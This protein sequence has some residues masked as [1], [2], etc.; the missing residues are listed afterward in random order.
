[1]DSFI[2]HPQTEAQE[3]AVQAV[4]EALDIAFEKKDLQNQNE[5]I[6]ILPPHVIEAIR[7]SEEQIK[8]GQF[9]LHE[10]VMKEFKKYLLI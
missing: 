5:E 1:M 8:N 4:L 10:E 9:Y 6:C 2:I 3:K 7:K